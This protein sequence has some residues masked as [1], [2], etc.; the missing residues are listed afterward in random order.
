MAQYSQ[1]DAQQAVEALAALWKS[2]QRRPLPSF[3]RLMLNFFLCGFFSSHLA[4]SEYLDDI[5]DQID[6]DAV[7]QSDVQLFIGVTCTKT[8]EAHWHTNGKC[9]HPGCGA[10]HSPE[11]LQRL[12]VASMS[13][14]GIFPSV[15]VD[16]RWYFDGGV[17]QIVPRIRFSNDLPLDV[18]YVE[19]Q[20]KKKVDARDFPVPLRLYHTLS[21]MS[22]RTAEAD[23]DHIRAAHPPH[24]VR[25]FRPTKLTGD[26]S[27]LS[28]TARDAQRVY[29]QGYN[30]VV[31]RLTEDEGGLR[32]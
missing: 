29:A 20:H 2:D 9:L 32:V 30:Q 15:E 7:A 23:I 22:T 3:F 24:M 31:R 11:E 18:I 27:V 21:L 1:R 17:S 25:F 5:T 28:F 10:I 19:A 13:I 8:A 6:W 12:V 26:N 4:G 14:P 16:G